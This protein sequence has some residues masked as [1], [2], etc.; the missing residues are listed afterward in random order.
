MRTDPRTEEGD[1]DPA[2]GRD[3]QKRDDDVLRREGEDEKGER[4]RNAETHVEA[5]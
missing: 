2:D 5:R 4:G 1:D 3:R